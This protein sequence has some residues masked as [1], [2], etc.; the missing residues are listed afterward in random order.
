MAPSLHASQVRDGVNRT[1]AELVAWSLHHASVGRYP[2]VG[3]Y[4][5]QFEKNTYRDKLK[6]KTIAGNYKFLADF[7]KVFFFPHFH[8]TDSCR[9]LTSKNVRRVGFEID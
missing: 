2:E 7:G 3:F 6:G 1:I 8:Q 9:K 4:G 5:E